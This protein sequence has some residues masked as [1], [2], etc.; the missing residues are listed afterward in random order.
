MKAWT[1]PLMALGPLLIIGPPL[2]A[3]GLGTGIATPGSPHNFT[4]NEA[5]EPPEVGAGGWNGRQEICRV[6][7]VPHDH[8]RSEMYG[9][10]GLLWNHKLSDATYTMY[11]SGTLDGS[12]ASQPTG[13]AKMCLACHD[14][15][16]G[17][18]T[19]DKYAGGN[20]F[21][22]DYDADFQTPGALYAGDL[23]K[24]HP[25]SIVYDEVADSDLNPKTDPMGGSGSIEDVLEGGTVVQ[26]SS[27]HDVHDQ[28]GES[29]PGTHLLRVAQTGG[30]PSGLCLT[31]HDK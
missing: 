16:V 29:V 22:G 31:C 10:V 6:C 12:Q 25:I 2:V 15:T 5:G 3:D 19:F 30:A 23:G 4:D 18:D 11:D 24:T 14:G 13:I 21:I 1:L 27:C 20:V 9:E 17:I 8:N 26:C 7:H 28:A